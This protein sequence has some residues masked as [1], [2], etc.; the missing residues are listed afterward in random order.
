M[1]VSGKFQYQ[2]LSLSESVM[3]HQRGLTRVWVCVLCE[4]LAV[5][6]YHIAIGA[7]NIIIPTINGEV[8][9]LSV[10]PFMSLNPQILRQFGPEIWTSPNV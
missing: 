2:G 5:A 8:F 6:D 4:T 9:F 1:Y 10:F 7:T 3:T